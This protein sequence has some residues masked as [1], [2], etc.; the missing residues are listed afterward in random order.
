MAVGGEHVGLLVFQQAHRSADLLE[1]EGQVRVAV[2]HEL[3][4][5]HGVARAQRAPELPVPGVVHHLDAGIPSGQGVGHL[6][7]AVGRGVVHEDDLVVG[8][9]PLQG[10]AGRGHRPVDVGLLVPHGEHHADGRGHGGTRVPLPAGDCSRPG[11]ALLEWR[12]HMEDVMD[13]LGLSLI[14][15]V[16]HRL[17]K[18]FPE[19]VRTAIAALTDAEIWARHN[20]QSNSLGNL[21][22]HLCGST[23]H[24]LG[25][26][27]G[28]SDYVR[29]RASEFAERGPIP[30]EELLR[31]LDETVAEAERVLGG[32]AP[33]RLLEKTDRTGKPS[34]V[35]ELLLR[36]SHHWAVH[37]GQIVFDV[38]VR[39]PGAF[40]EL[41]MKTMEKR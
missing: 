33:G 14:A 23:R 18:G 35:T 26:G 27:V 40:E 9:G 24:F 3:L 7:R 37:T 6:S 19:Q 12:L 29:D 2:E 31:R 28:G 11:P 1:V 41:W 4:G 32:L 36:V 17:V 5:G 13:E 25:R 39:K 10:L 30:R 15:E 20:E 38:K 8:G 34:T 16:R 21:V 22:L